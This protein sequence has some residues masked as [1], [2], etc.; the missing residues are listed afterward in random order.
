MKL[1]VSDYDGTIK[2]TENEEITRKNIEFLKKWRESGHKFVVATGRDMTSFKYESEKFGID[3]DGLILYNGSVMKR[4]S[5][6]NYFSKELQ[7]DDKKEIIRFLREEKVLGIG[8]EANERVFVELHPE[9]R[10]EE[11]TNEVVTLPFITLKPNIDELLGERIHQIAARVKSITH[12]KEIAEKIGSRL[13]NIT[14]YP[15][16]YSID[17]T[18]FGCSK[19]SAIEKL[20][21][22]E[23]IK[24]ENVF[25]IGDSHND[26]SMFERFGNSFSPVTA[27]DEIKENVSEV[28]EGVFSL[29]KFI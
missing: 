6:S 22:I 20:I 17:I 15:N 19:G 21:E 11:L 2:I 10:E 4:D 18:S 7:R 23:N 26:I 25:V 16:E 27:R 24:K 8:L 3:Y 12:A 14:A 29:K 13:K 28:V 9:N 5:G 1:L